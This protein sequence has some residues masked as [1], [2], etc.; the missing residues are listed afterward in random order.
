MAEDAWDRHT[1]TEGASARR[2]RRRRYRTPSEE[3]PRPEAAEGDS[4]EGE[5]PPRRGHRNAY[6]DVG[7]SVAFADTG[8]F[9][10]RHRGRARRMHPMA[11]LVRRRRLSRGEMEDL[12]SYLQRL[13][14][15]LVGALYRGLG[16]QP[17]RV[18]GRDRMIQLAVR[19]IAQGTRLGALLRSLPERDRQALAI[20]VQCGGLAHASEFHRELFLS[21]GGHE[22]EW[23]RVLQRLGERGLVFASDMRDEEFFYLVP[24]PLVDHLMEHLEAD[25]SL[26]TFRTDEAKVVDDRPFSPP[27]D[28]SITT[29]VTYMDQRPPRLTQRSEI[30]KLHKEE[31]DGFFAQLWVSDSELFAFHVD[32]LMMHGMVELRGDR[33]AVNRD[34]LEEWL[35]LD[36]EDQR[37]L[38]FQALEKRFPHAEWVLWAI[39]TGDGD[40]IP[41]KPLQAL[42]RRWVRG[43][44]WRRRYQQ[45]LYSQVRTAERESFTFASL[46]NAGMV[47]FGLWGQ[48][49]FY[50]LSPR[51]LNLLAPPRDDG[52]S[53]FYLT[54]S[55]EI[56][57]P[58]GLAP[59]LLARIGEL[60]ELT[61]CDRANTYK[62]NQ[63][64]IEQ[65]LARGWRRE[66]ILDFLRENSQTGL[67]ENVEQTLRS[68]MGHHG[69]AEFHDVVLLTVHRSGIRR[70]ESSKRLK[71]L[72]LHR[73]A[74]GL[75]VVDR[76]RLAEVRAGLEEAGFHPSQELR[77]YPVAS[78]GQ[79]ARERLA[80]AVAESRQAS[81][82][83]LARAH[84]RDTD[85]EDMHPVPGSGIRDRKS[86]RNKSNLPPRTTPEEAE[87]VV[88]EAL[89]SNQHLEMVYVTRDDRR[90]LVRVAP[91]RVAINREGASVLVARDVEKDERL[92]YRITQIERARLL[93]LSP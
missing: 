1:T 18:A 84:A 91:E 80:Q 71:P 56:M 11:G 61:G 89:S 28:F 62:I 27:L 50:R 36:C 85:P 10:R 70:L 37:E 74:P 63:A 90:T 77:R 66:E 88:L 19:A 40:W 13:P 47:Q 46:V 60:A 76:T 55:F 17:D 6:I 20:L 34:V 22:Q 9:P 48:E 25:L 3:A 33:L 15:P 45:G 29:L 14:E 30:Y 2:S 78:E 7:N 51:A 32:F 65:A 16:G 42:Y 64:T 26:P 92:T 87:K 43:E 41:D 79:V 38:I 73:F 23:R 5:R 12:T 68:W 81:E 69:D 8:R 35:N 44:D 31:M 67:P 24:H 52:F 4:T 82:D 39:H 83:P 57:A 59:I 21:L 86:R 93:P 75:Y 72:L 54:P 49:K 58:A 53:Q